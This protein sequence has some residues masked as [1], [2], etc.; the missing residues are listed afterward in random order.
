MHTKIVFFLLR[1]ALTGP[2]SVAINRLHPCSQWPLFALAPTHEWIG[3]GNIINWLLLGLAFQ[4]IYGHISL[5]RL[6]NANTYFNYKD[7]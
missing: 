2:R 6:Q 1:V 3:T 7:Q 5:L 4:F